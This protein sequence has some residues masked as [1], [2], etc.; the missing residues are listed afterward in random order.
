MEE[1]IDK[2]LVQRN[3]VET[4]IKAEQLIQEI[5]VKVA[6]KLITKPGKKF[7][8]DCK[9]ELITENSLWTSIESVKLSEAIRHWNLTVQNGKFLAITP[10]KK[11]FIEVLLNQEAE[12]IY[13]LDSNREN[14][15]ASLK[16]N[17]KIVDFSGIY[18]R[19][20]TS[21][22]VTDELD[23]CILDEPTL[24]MNK[25]LPFIHPFLKKDAF[26]VAVIKPHLE[27]DKEHLKNNG[28][29]RNSLCF[30]EMFE[31]LKAVG[32]TNNLTFEG[33]IDSPIVGKDGQQEF[34]LLFRK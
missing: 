26:V 20:L 11:A 14:V 9:I 31:Q 19:E 13:S 4:R 2:L 8:L 32:I 28:S 22:N 21:N 25:V 27:V 23:G 3:L 29:I 5:G 10:F 15:D 17:P 30:P 34:I 1:R 7:P 6:G 33:H 16:N 24:P 12:K 18:L